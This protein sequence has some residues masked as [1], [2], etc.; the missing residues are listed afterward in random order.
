MRDEDWRS[1]LRVSGWVREG[2][3]RLPGDDQDCTRERGRDGDMAGGM[4]CS[5][6][7][8][9]FCLSGKDGLFPILR[10]NRKLCFG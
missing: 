7:D 6:S 4:R 3:V 9:V 8:V 1:G 5:V 2:A 10:Y